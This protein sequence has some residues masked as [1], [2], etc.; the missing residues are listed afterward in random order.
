MLPFRLNELILVVA[1]LVVATLTA[2]LDSNHNYL[3][4]P[5]DSLIEIIRQ[6][7]LLGIF[8]LG[9]ALVIIAGGIDLSAGSMIA[10]SGTICATF[11]TLIAPGAMRGEDSLSVGVIAVCI[12]G[13]IMVG[14]L[15]GSMHAW[16]ITIIRLPPFVATLATLVGLRSLGRV[17]CENVTQAKLGGK[18]TQIQIYDEKFRY[19][20]TTVWI[21][22][23]IFLVLAIAI[24][25]LLRQTVVG[26]HIYALG[27]NEQAARLSGVQTDRVKWLAYCIGSLTSTIAGILYIGDQAVADPQTLG[28]GYELNAIAAAV[29]G[30]VSL[31]GGVGTVPG[32]IL[33]ALFLRAVIDGIAKVIKTGADVYEGLIVGVVVVVAVAFSQVRQA[34]RTGREAF[35]GALGI[36]TVAN[37]GL[38]T[39]VLVSQLAGLT[40]ALALGATVTVGLAGVKIWEH[41]RRGGA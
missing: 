35:P 20:G 21:P 25:F 40:W 17:I 9:A 4:N 18:S 6:T 31:Q 2:L 27:G 41:F 23:S 39:T 5:T 37:L 8:A 14:L 7:S 30:G 3:Q 19:L 1:I 28:R 16:L 29:V 32:T 11:M 15:V 13:T 34:L 10:F 38:L 12:V 26:R 22:A 24:W 36:V 33:G